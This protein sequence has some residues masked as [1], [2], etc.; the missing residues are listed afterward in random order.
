MVTGHSVVQAPQPV[1]FDEITKRGCCLIRTVKFPGWPSICSTSLKVRISMSLCL[2]IS[3][4]RGAMVH[5]AQSLVGKVLSSCAIT[6][7]IAALRSDRYTLIPPLA[8]S[9]A[10]CIPPIPPPTTSAAPT[11]GVLESLDGIG[12]HLHFRCWPPGPLPDRQEVQ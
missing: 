6:P 9:R 3:T 10:A 7:P 1:H 4:R 8:R 2:P 11:G 12:Y 5:M